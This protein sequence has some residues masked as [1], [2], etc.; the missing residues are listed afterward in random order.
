MNSKASAQWT[1]SLREGT[2]NVSTDSGALARVPYTFATR[3]AGQKGLNPEELLGA[4]HSACF[5]MAISAE[6]GRAGITPKSVRTQATVTL[7]KDGEGL[8]ITES[9]LD[10]IVEAPGADRAK[11]EAATEAAKAGCPLSKVIRAKVTM[12]A[13]YEV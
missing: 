6:L 7:D 10:V 11:V 5:S 13:Q 4:A 9:H 3:F 2:G 8:S 1:G 12:N